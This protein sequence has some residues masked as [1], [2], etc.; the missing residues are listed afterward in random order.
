[1]NSFLTAISL[2]A[3]RLKGI[4]PFWVHDADA[5]DDAAEKQDKHTVSN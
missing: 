4:F 5:P 1:V 2:T 3:F